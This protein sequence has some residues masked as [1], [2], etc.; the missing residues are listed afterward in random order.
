MN[1]H[2][3]AIIN[4]RPPQLSSRPLHVPLLRGAGPRL[5]GELAGPRTGKPTSHPMPFSPILRDQEK[6]HFQEGN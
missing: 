3:H 4:N 5:P 2:N 6:W 1:N